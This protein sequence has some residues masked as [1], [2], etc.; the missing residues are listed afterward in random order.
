[1]FSY[2][3]LLEAATEAKLPSHR[4]HVTPF[5]RSQP[6][7]FCIGSHVADGDWSHMRWT[8]DGP[9]DLEFVMEV[10]KRLYPLKPDFGSA[11]ILALLLADPKLGRINAHFERNQGSRKSLQAD[12]EYLARKT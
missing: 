6:E 8:V 5:I 3:A 12:A 11:E 9:E 4:E 10:Y 2:R 1:M 7:R